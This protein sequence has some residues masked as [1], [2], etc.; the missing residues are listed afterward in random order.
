MQAIRG[1]VYSV[2]L[3][4]FAAIAF[5][6]PATAQYDLTRLTQLAR[7]ALVGVG[8]DTPVT[9]FELLVLQHGQP[10]YHRAFGDMSLGEVVST[11]SSSKTMSG[12]LMMALTDNVSGFSLE[13]RLADYLPEY[14]KPGYGAI[15]LRQAFTHTSGLLGQDAGSSIL[16]NPNITLRQ[17]AALIA[18]TPLENGPPGSTFAYGGLSMQAAGAAAE[19]ATGASYTSLFD[20]FIADPLQL[21]STR[22]RLASPTNPRVAGG[23]ESTATD[24][25]RLM[26]ML[27][28][29]GVDRATGARVLSEAA[30]EEMLTRQTTDAQG[31]DQSPT[32]NNRYGIGVWLDQLT[33]AGPAVDALA[34]GARGFHSWIDQDE[35]LVFVFSTDRTRFS[36]VEELSSRMHTAILRAIPEPSAAGLL[37]CGLLLTGKRRRSS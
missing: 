35:G 33:Q 20:Q 8:V 14:R 36:N 4:A 25:A 1:A 2:L 32:D 29:N 21:Q 28:N 13:S 10:I 5:V 27:L 12:A 9:G 26:D 18:D 7:G 11:D 22:F 3:L 37:A 30:V 19:V 17:S 15:T 6:T 24:F 34:G 16:A 23:I 31:I